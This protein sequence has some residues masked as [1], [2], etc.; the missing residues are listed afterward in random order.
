MKINKNKPL[1]TLLICASVS[2]IIIISL[3]FR[4][5]DSGYSVGDK[6][7]DFSL[8][9]TDGS[10]VALSDYTA[11][12]GFILVFTCNHCPFS[13]KYEDRII[14]LH[15]KYAALGFPVVAINSNDATKQP[16]DSYANMQKRS[17]E[18]Q[19]PFAYLYDQ[20]QQIALAY[21]A[22]RTPHVYVLQKIDK[23]LVV[24]YIGAIDNNAHESTKIKSQYV[25]EAIKEILSG[26][27][28]SVSNTKAIGCTIKWK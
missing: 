27:P 24:R 7:K 28:V 11:A 20:D 1:A 5:T 22:A 10:P 19:F 12:K 3:A 14:D 21:G 15:R 23:D 26:M 18:K 2:L 6:A 13:I 8:K 25:Q 16:E 9:N 17:K 4:T